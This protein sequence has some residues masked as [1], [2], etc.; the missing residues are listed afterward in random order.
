MGLTKARKP[1]CTVT[2]AENGLRVNYF[3][4]GFRMTPE[5]GSRRYDVVYVFLLHAAG[6]TFLGLSNRTRET[7]PDT[8]HMGC[9]DTFERFL[10]A[11]F[12]F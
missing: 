11:G 3:L 10:S 12:N 7:I 4:K 1:D 2:A 8:S 9:L 5:Q 6:C